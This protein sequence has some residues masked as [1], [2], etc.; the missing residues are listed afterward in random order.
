MVSHCLCVFQNMH[1]KTYQFTCDL[2]WSS[3]VQAVSHRARRL[4]GLLYRQFY[5][6]VDTNTMTHLH[7]AKR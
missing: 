7:T 6:Y 4:A 2:T 3:H 5:Y 1:H